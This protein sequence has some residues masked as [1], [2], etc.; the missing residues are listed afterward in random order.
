[1]C[2]QIIKKSVCRIVLLKFTFLCI[3][4]LSVCIGN[5][6][7]FIVNFKKLVIFENPVA[8]LYLCYITVLLTT[9]KVPMLTCGMVPRRVYTSTGEKA[10]DSRV[11]ENQQ[12]HYFQNHLYKY[13]QQVPLQQ[14]FHRPYPGVIKAHQNLCILCSSAT[15]GSSLKFT[16]GKYK[17][18]APIHHQPVEY[19]SQPQ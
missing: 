8:A 7:F 12:H 3:V 17:N 10:G 18:A 1:M 4:I 9:A 11:L 19:A 5:S 16:I 13:R 14:A 6:L 15:A 2:I